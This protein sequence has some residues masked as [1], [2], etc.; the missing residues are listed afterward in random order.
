MRLLLFVNILFIFACQALPSKTL[1]KP[2]AASTSTKVGIPFISHSNWLA[3]NLDFQH[4]EKVRK[5]LETLIGRPLKHRGEAHITLISPPEF[6]SFAKV[7]SMSELE[8]ELGTDRVQNLEFEEICIGKGSK[9]KGS[10]Q[11]IETFFIVVESKAIRSLRLQ[12][13][14]ILVKRGHKQFKAEAF[15]PHITLGFDERDLHKE[16]GITKSR[17]SCFFPLQNLHL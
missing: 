17:A 8:K 7:I 4:Y 11:K 15:D 5:Q 6:E 14:D 3:V 13:Q 12:I 1:E 16:E 2:K 9:A 10:T